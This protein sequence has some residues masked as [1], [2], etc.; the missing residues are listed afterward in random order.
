MQID[1]LARGPSNPMISLSKIK[2]HLLSTH[3][4]TTFFAMA[5]IVL[6]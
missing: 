6:L 1:L 2:N 3:P 5:S 4:S